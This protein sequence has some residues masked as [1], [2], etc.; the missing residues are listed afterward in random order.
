M[1]KKKTQHE[2]QLKYPYPT[3]VR[4]GRKMIRVSWWQTG[5]DSRAAPKKYFGIPRQSGARKFAEEKALSFGEGTFLTVLKTTKTGSDATYY[6]VGK[7]LK[8]HRDRGG[9]KMRIDV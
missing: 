4:T 9:G 6:T 7:D 8:V 2:V 5:Q 1:G 3:N